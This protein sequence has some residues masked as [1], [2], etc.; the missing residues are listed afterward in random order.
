VTAPSAYTQIYGCQSCG[1]LI[2]YVSMPCPHCQWSPSN[3]NEMVRSVLLS[4]TYLDVSL[5][6]IFAREVSKGRSSGEVVG[7]LETM[8][9]E[10]MRIS[11]NR[12]YMDQLYRLLRKDQ[13][14]QTRNIAMFRKCP[15]CGDRKIWT[16]SDDELCEKCGAQ[17]RWP[18]A[19][20]A[21]VCM[22]NLLW[23]LEQ[24]VE[25]KN[26]E[27]FSEFVCVLVLMVNNLL[28]RQENPTNEQRRYALDLLSKIGAIADK[29]QGAIIDTNNPQ[30]LKIYF[31]KSNMME[32]SKA[33]GT[34][35][36]NQLQFFILKMVE[37]IH[38]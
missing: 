5:L 3:L 34:F 27:S 35:L 31:V 1:R 29:N 12:E 33:F 10:F 13:Q 38:L 36:C 21:L 4:N 19:V 25:P 22:D 6:L 20:R 23:L 37:G 30:T 11:K 7:N 15:G 9:Q 14:R 32:D 26:T 16:I 8:A 24:R 2:N 28:R 17:V 18:D